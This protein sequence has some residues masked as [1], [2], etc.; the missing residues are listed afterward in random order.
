MSKGKWTL[1]RI[2]AFVLALMMILTVP[3]VSAAA[4]I[5]ADVEDAVVESTETNDKE[6]KQ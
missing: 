4:V 1:N 2:F 5:D 6:E 3:E